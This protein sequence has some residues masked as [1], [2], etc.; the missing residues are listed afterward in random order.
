MSIDLSKKNLSG[1]LSYKLATLYDTDLKNASPEEMYR[2]LCAMLEELMSSKKMRFSKKIKAEQSKRVYYICMEFLIG[3]SLR[4]NLYN[5][6]VYDTVKEIVEESGLQLEDVFQLEPDAGIGNGGLGRLAACFLDALAT[7]QYAARGYSICYEYGIFRQKL[8]DGWQTELP[9][10]WIYNHGDV[11]LQEKPTDAVEIRFGGK[12]TENWKDGSPFIVHTDYQ[13]VTAMPC[14]M[15]ISGYDSEAVSTLRLFKAVSPK[16]D[17]A[18]FNNGNYQAAEG[19]IAKLT[20]ISKVLYPNDNHPEGK[21]LRLRQQYF[22]VSATINDIVR[23]HLKS[24]ATLENL[25]DKVAIHI[26]DTHPALGIAETMRILLDECG[27]S[28]ERAWE[29]TKATFAYTNHTVMKEALET[30]DENLVRTLLPRIY[31]IICEINRRFVEDL[32]RIGTPEDKVERMAIISGG[33]VKMA[34]LSVHGSH[35][36]NGVSSLH[37][38]IL[39]DTVFH[40]FYT[41]NPEKFTNVTNGI[42]Y[43]RWLQAGNPGLYNLMCRLSGGDVSKDAMLLE[44][45]LKYQDDRAVLDEVRAIKRDNKL[46]FNKFVKDT[47][48]QELNPDSIYDVQVKRM[49]EYKRQHLN[50]LHILSLYNYIKE[51]P[52]APFTPRTFIFAAKAAPG[53]YIAKQIIRLIWSIAKLIDSDPAMKGKLKVIY[54]EDYRVTLSEILMPAADISEQISLAGTEASGTGNMKLMLNGAVTLGTLD[55]ANV[56]IHNEV[57]DDN[58]VLFG[59]RNEDVVALKAKGYSPK[60]WYNADPVLKQ[61]VDMLSSGI[62]GNNFSDITGGLLYNDPF[63]VLADFDSYRKA[64]QKVGTLYE[65]PYGFAKKSFINTCKAGVF[66]ADR[67]IAQYAENIWHIKPLK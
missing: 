58:I 61:S 46:R 67:A 9:D 63:M 56:E 15:L 23:R 31:Q 6:G 16:F 2:V 28:W 12:I 32:R 65:D 22:L 62:M 18:A 21:E 4:N 20:A 17:M 1:I 13:T 35:S 45:G 36:V 34:N 24:Y 26:N 49:H 44:K 60:D 27:F 38:Q 40:D 57:G 50:A 53:Y 48:G 7:G 41:L 25:S 51:N 42:A 37:S 14:D 55:G 33:K 10:D 30:W 11:W 66:A 43:R 47:T 3:R 54:L 64:Q 8:E 59:M 52:N 5:L 39:K 19:E 29:I